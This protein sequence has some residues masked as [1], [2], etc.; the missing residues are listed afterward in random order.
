M[1][2]AAVVV[3]GAGQGCNR[4]T[5]PSLTAR[6]QQG[7]EQEEAAWG[8]TNEALGAQA[9]AGEAPAAE[10][11]A[12]EGH[13]APGCAC[14]GDQQPVLDPTVRGAVDPGSG[15][16]LEAVGEP[17]KGVPSV[18]VRE[19]LDRPM[20]YAGRAVRVEG[21]VS[22]MCHHK[23]RWFAV[24]DQGERGGR[25]LR[26]LAAP[27]FLVP[28]GSIGKEVRAEGVVEVVEVPAAALRH[29]ATQH[30]LG[31]AGD[32]SAPQQQ[33]VVRAAGAEFF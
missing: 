1:V 28:A 14:G 5:E 18:R 16:A 8:P 23:R 24:Q 32:P 9:P 33:V 25:Y 3:A 11:G 17:L 4:P 26:V 2:A 13:A 30:G 15:R 20:H 6:E 19:L 22:A 7:L 10:C 27:A 12:E 21:D 29:Q 31:A